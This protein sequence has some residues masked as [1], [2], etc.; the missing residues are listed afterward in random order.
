MHIDELDTPFVVVDLDVMECNL[1][2]MAAYCR[3]RGLSLRPHSKTHKIP[4]IA[5]RQMEAGA[6]GITVAK[7]GEA[8]VMFDAGIRDIL[9]AY[10]I[11]T[12]QKAR[13]TAE[14]AK[15]ARISVS[16]DSEEAAHNLSASARELGVTIRVLVEIDTGFRRCGVQN[17]N[18]AIALAR[19]ISDLGG[20]EFH[21][22]MFYPGHMFASPEEQRMLLAPV[23][24]R[25]DR[26]L[27]SF[28]RAGM[29]LSVVTGGSTPTAYL[30]HE[31]HGMTEIRPGMYIFNDR[32]LLGVGAAR[33]EDC[34]LS[35]IATVVS[36]AVP[37][38]VI[39]DSGS[40]TLSS[41]GCITGGKTGYG[42]ITGDP[43]AQLELMS[44]EHGH[45]NITR[46]SR[47]YAIGDRVR[48]IPNHVCPTVN[49]HD[50][51]Y[52]ARQGRVEE[53]WEVAGRGKVR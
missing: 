34:A 50:E 33:I 48:I 44:E 24:E 39:L 52:A 46:S 10:P 49:M 42:L 17:E 5:L 4:A 43:E 23:N 13:R 51:I 16:L 31:F 28:C 6:I 35:V 20:L 8:E 11:V 1:A 53:V 19:I 14:L 9:I 32:N 38:R 37:G 2:R 40:K 30:S 36:T 22:L 25:L 3:E 45:L 26:T 12:K 7:V 18:E 21:G 41:D 15:A 29:H 27:D 47:K